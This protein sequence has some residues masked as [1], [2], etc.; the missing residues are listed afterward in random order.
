M[1]RFVLLGDGAWAAR[2]LHRLVQEGHLPVGVVV[3]THP[4]TSE[5]A[6][7]ALSLGAPLLA[8][9]KVNDPP[10]VERIRSL[11][12]DLG[13]SI[14]YN[15][16]LR[17][18]LL[19]VPP[20]GFLNFHAGKLPNY[21][22]RNIVNWALL[23]GESEIG[24]TAHFV[25]EGIDTGDIVL[26]KTLAVGWTET[27]GDLLGRIVALM[28]DLVAEAVA[29]VA[30]GR[31]ERRPQAHVAATYFAGREEGDEWLDWRESSVVLHNKVRAITRPG[32]GARTVMY[33]VPVTVWSAYFDPSWPRYLATPGQVVGRISGEGVLVKSGDSH[34]LLKEVQVG[35][36]PAAVPAWPIGTRL[37]VDPV[38]TLPALLQR[39]RSLEER[40]AEALRNHERGRP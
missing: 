17:F 13:I 36:G 31:V 14:A 11:G 19:E 27:Y 7:A 2:S 1:L 12:P 33:D 9:A 25:D 30:G 37:G 39:L 29:L 26:Q 3:R 18:P 6:D 22:G 34:L 15:Q 24:V 21:R 32:P 23:N 28:P 35:D 20:H 10:I 8:P 16:I 38:S 5:L 4:S 40:L